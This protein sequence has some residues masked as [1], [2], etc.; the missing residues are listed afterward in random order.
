MYIYAHVSGLATIN[1]VRVCVYIYI[2]T[3]IYRSAQIWSKCV[4]VYIY[5]HICIYAYIEAHIFGP[6]IGRRGAAAGGAP[7]ASQ[8]IQISL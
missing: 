6:A 5:I 1:C 7:P 3:C 8:Y 4:C 2:C